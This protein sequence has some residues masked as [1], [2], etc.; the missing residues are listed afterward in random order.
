MNGPQLPQQE[1]SGEENRAQLQ[2]VK[3]EMRSHSV[4]PSEMGRAPSLPPMRLED[5]GGGAHFAS[6]D[7]EVSLFSQSGASYHF[8]SFWL[9]LFLGNA[10]LARPLGHQPTSHTQSL[11]GL[12]LPQLLLPPGEAPAPCPH[13][14]HPL[15]PYS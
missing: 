4:C 2:N 3:N 6:L 14:Y 1:D 8:P 15:E 10:P 13:P 12:P 7:A 9:L 5:P 11:P